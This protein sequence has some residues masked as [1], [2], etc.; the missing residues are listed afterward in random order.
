M[1]NIR[2]IT[3]KINSVY[4]EDVVLGEPFIDFAAR[5]SSMRGTT[6]LMSGGDLDCARFHILAAK[7]WLTFT[8][9]GPAMTVDSDGRSVS[10]EADPFDTLRLIL[11]CCRPDVIKESLMQEGLT[12]ERPLPVAAGLFGY[13]SYDLKDCLENL[14]RTSIDDL[15]LPHILFFAPSIIVVHDKKENNTKLL[16]TI[17]E[18]EGKSSLKTD[19]D[20]FQKTVSSQPV[21]KQHSQEKHTGLTSNL[22]KPEYIETIKKIREYIASG[23]VYQVNMSQRFETDFSQDPFGLFKDLYK[24]NPAPFFAF[25]NAGDHQVVST[26]PE[27]FIKQ[28]GCEV[29]T[30]PIKGTCP[31]GE[32]LELDGKLKLELV[33]SKKND[34]ELSMIVDLLRNDLGKVC[35]GGSVRVAEHKKLEQYENVYHLVSTVKG[36]LDKDRDSVDL[37]KA[38]FPGGSITGCPKIRSMEIIDELE[39]NRRHIYTGSIGYISFHDTMDLSVAIRTATVL[40]KRIIFSVGGGIVFDSD[41]ADEYEETLHK[42]KTLMEIFKGG[43][44]GLK[45]TSFAWINGRIK[46]MEKT[47]IPASDPGFQYGYGFF[48][49]I[50][51]DSCKPKYLKE[52]IQ[53]FYRAWEELFSQPVPDITWDEV[54]GQVLFE[55]NLQEKTAAIKIVATKG[56]RD[57]PPYNN[58]VLVTAG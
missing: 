8:G 57:I 43:E 17:R 23:H 49:T 10:F 45:N 50:R 6:V 39:P 3:G 11:N 7:P 53:R 4:S 30:R 29:E 34:A 42:G 54:I 58:T 1:D 41:P 40:N 2:K 12:Q 15:C 52:H 47:F 55:N 5:F 48:E 32:T 20:Y 37:V 19:L 28:T 16:I 56:D 24:T 51:A 14:P 9:R 36:V 44:K 13:L 35:E 25:I 18:V 33:E 22:T 27:R 31:R 21:T 46:P 26:S 38:T